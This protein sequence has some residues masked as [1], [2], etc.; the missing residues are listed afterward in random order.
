VGYATVVFFGAALAVLA[1]TR[2]REGRWRRRGR[3]GR[4]AE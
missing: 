3:P 1:L 4:R 2:R